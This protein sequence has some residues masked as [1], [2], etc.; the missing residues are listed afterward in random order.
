MNNNAFISPY[1]R[2]RALYLCDTMKNVSGSDPSADTRK[3][4]V[5]TAR[6]MVCQVLMMEGW[7]ENQIGIVMGWDH[8]TVN[9]YRKRFK[10]FMET[11]MFR[12]ERALWDKFKNAI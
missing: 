6:V 8:S 5:V 7:S 9:H 4:P 11:P 12:N 3:R 1:M 10:E 2:E